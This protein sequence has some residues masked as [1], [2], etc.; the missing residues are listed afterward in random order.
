MYDPK[1]NQWFLLPKLPNVQ[2]S[3]V[4]VPDKS[5]V[6]YSQWSVV[7]Q[8]PYNIQNSIPLIIGDELYIANG[9][10]SSWFHDD[11]STRRIVSVSMP[12]L[13][14]SNDTS[15]SLVWNKLPDM[16][17]SSW[18]I[19]HYQGCLI[20]VTGDHKVKQPGQ[21]K[22][23]WELISQIHLYNPDTQSWELVGDVPYNYLMGKSVHIRENELLFI[24]GITGTLTINKA[25]D[26]LTTCLTLTLTPE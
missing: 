14:Q 23:T 22:S 13:L 24:G 8:L 10:C 19:N 26:M 16:P 9:F 6:P 17:Y 3:L 12:E 2:F 11:D 7:K 15:S 20:I 18:S 21:R 1:E 5:H 25:N 4:S